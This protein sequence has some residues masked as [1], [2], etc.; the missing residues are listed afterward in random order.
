MCDDDLYESS[1]LY[2]TEEMSIDIVYKEFPQDFESSHWDASSNTN[3][4]L[5][6]E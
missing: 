1:D 2:D 6:Y 3:Q 5:Y 4:H